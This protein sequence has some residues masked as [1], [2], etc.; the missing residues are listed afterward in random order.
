MTMPFLNSSIAHVEEV[1]REEAKRLGFDEV[2]L[3]WEGPSIMVK[4]GGRTVEIKLS[5]Q[6]LR[7]KHF[8]PETEEEKAD[9]EKFWDEAEKANRQEARK[10]EENLRNLI[11]K[12]LRGPD[13]DPW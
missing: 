9:P 6:Y 3:E 1:V 12:D 4:I 2:T 13:Q 11:R 7:F 8:F 10:D 5:D